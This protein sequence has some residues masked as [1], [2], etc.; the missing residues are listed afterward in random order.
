MENQKSL[1]N[2]I[3]MGSV[4]GLVGTIATTLIVGLPAADGL[5]QSIETKE[6]KI[7]YGVTGGVMIAGLAAYL[8][9]AGN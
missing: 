5:Y 7:S 2:E 9:S 6:G 3:T 4:K 8:F 1:L